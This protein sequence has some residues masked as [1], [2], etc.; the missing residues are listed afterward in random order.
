MSFKRHLG[1]ALFLGLIVRIITSFLV[2]GAQSV[3]DYSHGL[4][5][6]LEFFEGKP[7]DLPMWRSPLLVWSLIPF[8]KLG[9]FLGIETQFGLIRCILLGLGLFSMLGIWAFGRWSEIKLQQNPA[10]NPWLYLVPLYLLSLHFLMP[11]ASTRAFGESI[12]ITL[13]LIGF[14]LIEQRFIFW[15]ALLLGVSCLY[16]FQV[17]LLAFGFASYFLLARQWKNFGLIVLA[18]IATALL[19]ALIDLSYGRWPLETLYNYFYVNKDGAVEHSIQPWYNTWATLLPIWFLPFSLPL[20]TQLKK[21]EKFEK[22]W[23]GVILFFVLL[24]SLIP[25]KEERFLFP[26]L[27]LMLVLFG[28][29]WA[30]AWGSPFEKWFFRPFFGTVLALGLVVA[31]ISNSQAGEYEPL[32]LA[33]KVRGPVLIWD[34]N[35]VLRISFFRHRLVRPPVDYQEFDRW[36]S[37][38]ELVPFK[39]RRI[40]FVT[41]EISHLE[42]WERQSSDLLAAGWNCADKIRIQSLADSVI[43]RL[44]PKYN[45]R[46][47]PT[48]LMECSFP[49][50]L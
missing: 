37:A 19:E 49:S 42:E 4:L 38:T 43:Y 17:G 35:S 47:K 32:R 46:R 15:G 10:Q 39:D 26:I 2:Y 3:D 9:L 30:R 36:P 34:Y 33:E 16:R 44:N 31:S 11:F 40:F 7:F 25:H 29:I 12:A 23:L 1:T 48:F 13:V 20:M 24:H 6:T 27:P 14:L 5:P 18:G 41:S 28:R 8:A 50:A 45:T 22:V 21:M